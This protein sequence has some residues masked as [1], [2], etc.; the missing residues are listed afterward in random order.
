MSKKGPPLK[1]SACGEKKKRKKRK[2]PLHNVQVAGATF[3][4][5]SNPSL[6]GILKACCTDHL[7]NASCS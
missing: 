7:P 1:F 4:I 5:T 6:G 3:L 2:K